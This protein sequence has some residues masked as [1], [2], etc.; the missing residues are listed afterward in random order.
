MHFKESNNRILLYCPLAWSSY[1]FRFFIELSLV[2]AGSYPSCRDVYGNT[3]TVGRACWHGG[4]L[5]LSLCHSFVGGSY[6]YSPKLWYT[7]L[8]SVGGKCVPVLDRWGVVRDARERERERERKRERQRQRGTEREG[9]RDTEREGQRKRERERERARRVWLAGLRGRYAPCSQWAS[10]APIRTRLRNHWFL[11]ASRDIPA[12]HPPTLS[13][14][15]LSFTYPAVLATPGFRFSYKY[16]LVFRNHHQ[17]TIMNL[18][19]VAKFLY[20]KKF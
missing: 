4:K 3:T 7:M 6:T 14:N 1:R 19:T 9:E 18:S 17:Q 10:V 15:C 2:L 13:Y 11:H 16:S 12:N 8:A 20:K 5:A